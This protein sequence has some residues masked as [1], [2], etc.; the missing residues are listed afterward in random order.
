MHKKMSLVRV[1]ENFDAFCDNCP[2]GK[3]CSKYHIYVRP[4]TKEIIMKIYP[5]EKGVREREFASGAKIL[6]N[7]KEKIFNGYGVMTWPSKA[8]Y[9]GD[10]LNGLRHGLGVFKGPDG[11]EYVGGWENGMRHGRG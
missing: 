5:L 3:L 7:V 11:V 4:S 1:C 6:C 8:V 9:M 2:E 10:W